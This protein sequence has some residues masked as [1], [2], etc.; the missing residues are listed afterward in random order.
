MNAAFFWTDVADM[1]R[2]INVS[3]ATSGL[4]QSIY[5]TADARIRGAE[6]EA[7]FSPTSTIR[8]RANAGYLDA[9]YRRIF[10]D[11]SGDGRI[12]FAD[13]GL[14]LPRAPEWTW[15]IGG[16]WRRPAGQAVLVARADFQHRAR[17]AYTDNNYGWIGAI[18]SLD[19]SIGFD[20]GNPAIGLSLYGRN[21]LDA[22]QFGGDTQLG[23][24][25]GPNSDGNNRP[26]DARPA[27]GTF[28]PLMKGRRIGI[29][30]SMRF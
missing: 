7:E 4:A 30:M 8:L 14:R 21:L 12:D 1:Q 22:V 3:S 24:A 19:A 29:E 25:G 20:L 2:E 10:Y 26:F 11:I 16:E 6:I 17:Y 18:D 28:S 5:N 9:R 27:A 23:F 13:R 15:G